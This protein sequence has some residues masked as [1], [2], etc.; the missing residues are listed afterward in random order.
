MTLVD[1]VFPQVKDPENVVR[2]MSKKSH[3]RESFKKQH[4]KLAQLLL[5]CASQ[6][7]SHIHWSVSRQLSWKKFLLLTF[8]FLGLLVIILAAD[9]KCPVLNRD[10]S[11]KPS[12]MQ[13]SQKKTTFSEVFATFLK[14]RLNFQHFE[15]KKADPNRFC[16]SE[17]TDF[18]NVRR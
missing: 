4:G 9:D 7:L 13:L 11:T 2:W 8:Q 10:N 6:H 18:E 3:F 12:Q 14:C 17:I 5:K 15:K 16:I 1:F